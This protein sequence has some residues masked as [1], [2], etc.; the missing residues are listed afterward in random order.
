MALFWQN[1]YEATSLDTLT[2]RL[3]LS[4]SSL[5]AC[6]GSK[7]GMLMRAL[8]LYAAGLVARIAAAADEAAGDD[9]VA[10]MLRVIATTED[11]AHGCLLV[12]CIA[13]LAPHDDELAGFARDQLAAVEAM[14]T[15]RLPG[16]GPERA[17]RGRALV[18]LG[19]GA[20]TMRK[21]GIDPGGIDAMLEAAV[22]LL[23]R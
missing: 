15:E 18:A 22:P 12:N 11:P 20:L 7:R 14:V 3:G 21:S 8:E 5:Y 23:G 17:V 16:G 13:E 1:G 10:A 6:F 4:R 19:V 2:R 9:A